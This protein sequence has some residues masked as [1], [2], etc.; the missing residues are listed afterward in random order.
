MLLQGQLE[1]GRQ[2]WFY[3]AY[4]QEDTRAEIYVAKRAFSVRDSGPQVRNYLS[5]SP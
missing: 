4:I 5:D 2:G 1:D 3:G